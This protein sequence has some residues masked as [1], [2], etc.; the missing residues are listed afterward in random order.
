[1][2][3][4]V[5]KILPELVKEHSQSALYDIE[6]KLESDA[7]NYK[8]VNYTAI[9]PL[10]V[11]SFQ[12]QKIIADALQYKEDSLISTLR[13]LKNNP[14]MLGKSA[15]ENLKVKLYPN[16]T[17][18]KISIQVENLIDGLLYDVTITDLAGKIFQQ[19]SRINSTLV[20]FNVK[21]LSAGVYQYFIFIDGHE[22]ASGKF[23][24]Q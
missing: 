19:K 7:L 21:S 14:Y 4:D 5:E 20:D 23:L 22:K 2:A 1:M 17:S 10:L 13:I 8:M 18:E 3:Q 9:I 12:E 24:K 6:G 11:A 15:V 16:P